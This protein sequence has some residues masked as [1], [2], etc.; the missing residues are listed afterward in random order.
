MI[1]RGRGKS[2]SSREV[3]TMGRIVSYLLL[4]ILLSAGVSLAG[5]PLQVFYSENSDEDDREGDSQQSYI[6]NQS[7]L[8]E[9]ERQRRARALSP[10]QQAPVGVIVR[11]SS[12]RRRFSPFEY[13]FYR[14]DESS[15][16]FGM[17]VSGG[18]TSILYYDGYQPNCCAPRRYYRHS[19]PVAVPYRSR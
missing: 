12:Q 16:F 14:N 11:K 15:S 17:E 8:R 13:P 7:Y 9:F 3:S 4:I 5:G 2:K 6:D 1:C 10:P 18:A 19:P